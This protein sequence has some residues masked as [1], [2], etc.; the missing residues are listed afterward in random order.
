MLKNDRLRGIALMMVAMFAFAANDTFIKLMLV[1]LPLPQA[2]VVRGVPACL[3]LGFL[4]WRAGAFRHF[5]QGKDRKL[6]ILR[7]FGEVAATTSFLTALAHMPLANLTAILQ[8]VPLAAT[9]AAAIFLGEKVG[10]R[11]TLAVSIGFIGVLIVIRPGEDG[12]SPWALLGLVSVASVVFRDLITRKM[13]RDVP[14]ALTGLCAAGM[15]WVMG[16]IW[17]AFIPWEPVTP[18]NLVEAVLGAICLTAAFV[19]LV[20]A[21]QVGD[22]GMTAPLRYSQ[23]LWATLLGWLAFGHLP[24][25]VTLGG[26]ALIVASG[27]FTVLREARRRI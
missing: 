16:A 9:F 15:V 26:A 6:L 19:G 20:T 7:S 21:L 8:S 3:L 2:I 5:P 12:L 27:V 17:S 23:L 22:V 24:D 13:S 10:W 1:N 11:R 18:Q 4:A 25:L 14:A